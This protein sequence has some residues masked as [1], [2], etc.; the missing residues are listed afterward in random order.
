MTPELRKDFSRA[1]MI[2]RSAIP[3]FPEEEGV[4]ALVLNEISCFVG[5][6]GNVRERLEWFAQS[7]IRY[8]KTWGPEGCNLP[9]LRAL[10]CTRYD[11][12]DRIQPSV[13]LQ[14][15]SENDLEARHYALEMEQNEKRM[16]EYRRSAALNPAEYQPLQLEAPL[17]K[18]FPSRKPAAKEKPAASFTVAQE[19]EKNLTADLAQAPRR[20]DAERARIIAEMEA[21][22]RAV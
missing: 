17:V 3:F 10:Y 19:L 18:P 4:Q 2:L 8:F 1:V 21:K 14:G 12:A 15:Y 11:P 5:F 20:S 9:N 7:A 22:V 16:L 13:V 6:S